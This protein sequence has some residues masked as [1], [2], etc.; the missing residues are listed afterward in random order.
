[1][2]PILKTFQRCIGINELTIKWQKGMIRL[3]LPLLFH[4]Q[5]KEAKMLLDLKILESFYTV[6]RE[7]T[8]PY[9][10]KIVIGD[11]KGETI[12]LEIN[13]CR[14]DNPKYFSYYH[15]FYDEFLELEHEL[16][17]KEDSW[18]YYGLLNALRKLPGEKLDYLTYH[19]KER[20]L[21]LPKK[22]SVWEEAKDKEILEKVNFKK[23]K[24]KSFKKIKDI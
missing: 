10:K 3:R 5:T 18:I 4:Y 20:F 7:K 21:K 1:M 22:A 16:W 6:V 14:T 11:Y 19:S 12:I 2:E 24:R 13:Y 23:Q 17:E 8:N 9:Y 15:T